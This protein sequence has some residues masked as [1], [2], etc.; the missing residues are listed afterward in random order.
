MNMTKQNGWR[1]HRMAIP[2]F[3]KE[4]IPPY[5]ATRFFDQLSFIGDELVGCFLVETSEGLLLLDCMNP[6]DRCSNMIEKGIQDLGHNMNELKVIL[7]THGHGDHFG[8]AGYFKK[9]YHTRIYMSEIDYQYAASFQNG[10]PWDALDYQMDGYLTDGELFTLGDTTIECIFTPGHTLGCFSFLIP[11]TDEGTP[12][13]MALWGGSGIM[14]DT[15][16]T[17]Y[18]NSWKKFSQICANRGVDGEIATHPCLDQGLARLDI[19]R[20][21]VDGIPNPFVLGKEGYQYY[22]KIFYNL[23]KQPSK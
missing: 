8:K 1:R 11:V 7:V 23:C 21:I 19:V 6:D 2:D 22:E 4:N 10:K 15:D 13:K 3:R 17:V 5:P 9:K 14:P 18:L 16:R 20:N 12:H